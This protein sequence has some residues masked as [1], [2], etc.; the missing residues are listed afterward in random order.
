MKNSSI[1]FCIAAAVCATAVASTRAFG[2]WKPASRPLMTE[3]GAK[4]RPDNA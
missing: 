3:W 2:E 1:R 4:V